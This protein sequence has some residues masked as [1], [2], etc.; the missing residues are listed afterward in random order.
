[1]PVRLCFVYGFQT[2]IMRA[3]L[4]NN[5]FLEFSRPEDKDPVAVLALGIEICSYGEP[6]Y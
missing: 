2:Q 3:P 6:A 5:L 4:E 1:M